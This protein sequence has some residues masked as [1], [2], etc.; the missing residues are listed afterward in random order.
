MMF[1]ITGC[2]ASVEE[3]EEALV[4]Q[5][6]AVAGMWQTTG[7]L[8]QARKYHTATV[9]GSGRV[10][11]AGGSAGTTYL[12][13]A[14]VYDP[15]AGTW[16]STGSL[17]T[18]RQAHVT[19]LLPSGKVLVAGGEGTNRLA[20][21]ELYDPA[22][23]TWSSAGSFVGIA[24][25]YS[26]AVV[27][28]SGRVLVIGGE[29]NGPQV[30]VD[31]YDPSTAAWSAGAALLTRRR[32]HT[33]TVLPSGKV[34]VAGGKSNATTAAAEVYDPATNSWTA[35]GSMST[36]RYDHTATLLP[37]GRVLVAGG[38]NANGAAIDTAEVYDPAT[39]TWITTGAMTKARTFHTATL[40]GNKV[41]VAG[42]EAAG[43]A[44][45][46]AEL[47]DVATGTWTATGTLAAA[48]SLH[49]AVFLSA[50]NKVLV[51]AGRGVTTAE[52]YDASGS[53][54]PCTT[55]ADCAAGSYCAAGNCT[56][57]QPNG[58][59]C[60]SA[61]QCTSGNCVDGVCCDSTCGEACDACNL[62]GSVGTCALSPSTVQCRAAA[63][64]CDAAE[65]CTGTNAT[66]P[67]NAMAPT[68][69]VCTDDGNGCTADRCDGAGNCTHPPLPGG[70]ACGVGGT[71][72]G[73][74][75]CSQGCVIGGTAYAGGTVNP[76]NP[77]QVCDPL[78]S[79]AAWSN[80]PAT[81]VCSAPSYGNW[82]ACGGFGDT[83]DQ[84]G[85]RSRTVTV[86]TCGAGTC[87]VASTSTEAQS[88][89]R[90]TTGITCAPPDY[91]GWGACTRTGN[92][93]STL[94][95]Q[96]RTVAYHSCS[97]GTCGS[98]YYQESQDCT[99]PP[100]NTACP[101]T[102]YGPWWGPNSCWFTSD[103]A[104]TGNMYRTVTTYSFDCGS[105][106][107]VASSSTQAQAC[108]RNPSGLPCNDGNACTTGDS[109]NASGACVS[110][111]V[112]CGYGQTC[113]G[114]TCQCGPDLILCNGQCVNP[115]QDPNNC[116]GCGNKCMTPKFGCNSGF[117]EQ[118]W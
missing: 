28:G 108:S 53:S 2:A 52:L 85:T 84:S 9:L 19:A 59:A 93:C 91:Y 68:S 86:L 34:L 48:R 101:A 99:P 47:Y 118:N 77:C 96:Y 49:V 45:A 32:S 56:A 113:V 92:A 75:Q 16:A 110:T 102:E 66:C 17:T 50:S 105:G 63:G 100:A 38:V 73:S 89:S 40:V 71:C 79:T 10:L 55:D 22:L 106:Q 98:A 116:G 114:G 97:S 67:A 23:G 117:C 112:T 15:V 87:G 61:N 76:G 13:S 80:R 103:C 1:A 18:A 39:G 83:C 4:T 7:T 104:P 6:A 69:T 41:L 62:A 88:C 70:S 115:E 82:G 5:R 81:T 64:E 58:V 3:S 51:A 65:Y 35:T 24:R 107:C 27:L 37:D 90:N 54:N 43:A 74:G 30:A 21:A 36:A 60:G 12:S 95:I 46:L 31:L 26:A 33:A 11:V 42:G 57:K 29:A 8:P 25:A 109:C 44:L 78:Q 14:V 20:S 94:G 111:P 72:N